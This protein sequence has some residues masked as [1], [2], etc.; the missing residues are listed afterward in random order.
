MFA[1]DALFFSQLH[2]FHEPA[3]ISSLIGEF[4]DKPCRS[5]LLAGKV[6]LSFVHSRDFA[7]TLRFDWKRSVEIEHCF[8]M[9]WE[10][11]WEM[12]EPLNFLRFFLAR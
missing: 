2:L 12:F 7:W 10:M 9:F 1:A 4:S 6:S 8:E 3:H 11:F 5:C